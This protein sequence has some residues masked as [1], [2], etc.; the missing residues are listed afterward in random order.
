MHCFAILNVFKQ[1]NFQ[2]KSHF[3]AGRMCLLD[4]R[5]GQIIYDAQESRRSELTNCQ[6][7]FPTATKAFVFSLA[8]CTGI[9]IYHSKHAGHFARC[10]R[11]SDLFFH[12]VFEKTHSQRVPRNLGHFCWIFCRPSSSTTLMGMIHDSRPIG[13][14]RSFGYPIHSAW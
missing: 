7:E 4:S 5:V 11:A 10:I 1:Y 2:S 12:E 9:W 3:P 8:K 13:F 14:G 6:K